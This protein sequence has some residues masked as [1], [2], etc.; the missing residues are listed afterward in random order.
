MLHN[1]CHV[2]GQIITKDSWVNGL[3]PGVSVMTTAQVVEMSVTNDS[4]SK[5]RL[6]SPRR[7]CQTNFKKKIPQLASIVSSSNMADTSLSF[8]CLGIDCKPSLIY[9]LCGIGSVTAPQS[10]N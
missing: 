7:S 5:L 10:S 9:I 4:L 2:G 3:N 8:D 1:C 6:L